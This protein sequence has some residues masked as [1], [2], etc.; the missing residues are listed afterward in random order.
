MFIAL[1]RIDNIT[2]IS[3]ASSPTAHSLNY[4]ALKRASRKREAPVLNEDDLEET[5][6]KGG[7]RL[8]AAGFPS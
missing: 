7:S 6:I 2:H 4:S 1:C 5:F 8:S 3:S